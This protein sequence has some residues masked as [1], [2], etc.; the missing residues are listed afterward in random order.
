MSDRIKLADREHAWDAA[1][2][3]LRY[4]TA[5]LEFETRFQAEL[6]EQPAVTRALSDA[7]HQADTR[8]SAARRY[9]RAAQ[10][11]FKAAT[12]FLKQQR[13]RLAEIE[14]VERLQREAERRDAD[15]S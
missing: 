5:K 4:H 8:V 13:E 3:T 11:E 7:Y 12:R 6:D 15:G 10:T 9:L 2:L 1:E 14:E